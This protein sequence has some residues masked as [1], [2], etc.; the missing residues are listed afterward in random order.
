MEARPDS[1]SCYDREI[2]CSGVVAV[3]G[4]DLLVPPTCKLPF[5]RVMHSRP[6]SWL[7]VAPVFQA[8]VAKGL[9]VGGEGGGGSKQG[10][11]ER[12]FKKDNAKRGGIRRFQVTGARA[13]WCER[14][15]QGPLRSGSASAAGES[16]A[17][18]RSGC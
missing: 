12:I 1:E 11:R 6:S 8:G 16:V 5:Q 4:E 14:E 7:G 10:C 15:A 17:C 2:S 3:H 13:C 18:V 9:L